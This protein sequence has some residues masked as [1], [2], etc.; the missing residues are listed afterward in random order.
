MNFEL[1]F[2]LYNACVIPAWLLLAFAPKHKITKL[3]VYS[4]AYPFFLGASYIALMVFGAIQGGEGGMNSLECLRIAFESD[5]TLLLAWIHYIVFDL[6]IG[7]WEVT[8]AQKHNINHWQVVPCLV[9]TLFLGPIGLLL[10]LLL[11]WYKT[12][13]FV[14]AEF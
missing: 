12:G 11:R 10:Y 9:L 2:K 4:Y 1:L 14:R 6:F 3:V 8:D 13:S 5:A 7:T